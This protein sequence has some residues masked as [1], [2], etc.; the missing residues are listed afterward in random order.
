V[1]D[2]ARFPLLV[3]GAAGHLGRRVIAHLLEIERIR[4]ADI[5]ATTRRPEALADLA[6]RGVV[7]RKADF[8]DE[9]G[10]A[11]AFEGARRLLLISTDRLDSPCIRL[12]QHVRAVQAATTAGVGHIVYTSMPK[13]E[14]GSPIPFSPDHY[15]TEQ[16]LA[17]SGRSFTVLRNCWYMETLLQSLPRVLASGRWFTAAGEGRIAYVSRDDCARTA[18]AALASNNV[19][20]A[21]HTVT[22]PDALTTREIAQ[23]ASGITGKVI[24]VIQVPAEALEQGLLSAGL[25]PPIA[26]LVTA[27][28]LNTAAGNVAEVTPTVKQL[29]GREPE[30]LRHFLVSHSAT[31]RA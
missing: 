8:D 5:I 1:T 2:S 4:P 10:L 20:H 17:N 7:V 21:T 11:A 9:T 3:T 14:P 22:G 24:D 13:P 12:S 28:D 15:G 18:A 31:F 27:F 23:L 29:T 16:V 25:P 30:S 19:S 26:A 6:G